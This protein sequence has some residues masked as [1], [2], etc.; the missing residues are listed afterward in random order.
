[1]HAA[2]VI[3]RG[4]G[5]RRAGPGRRAAISRESATRRRPRSVV[6]HDAAEH[7]AAGSAKVARRAEAVQI[8]AVRDDRDRPPARVAG[9]RRA[10]VRSPPASCSRVRSPGARTARAAALHAGRPSACGDGAIHRQVVPFPRVHV[11]HVEHERHVVQRRLEREACHPGAVGEHDVGPMVG[12]DPLERPAKGRAR[13][14][15]ASAVW[16][17]PRPATARAERETL[18]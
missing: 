2:A 12:D 5:A 3:Q 6:V 13:A 15:R 1:M 17:S 4:G 18:T 16:P 10:P 7:D 14:S 11:D 8:N 9:L